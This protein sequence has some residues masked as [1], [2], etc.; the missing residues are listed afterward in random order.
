MMSTKSEWLTRRQCLG[1]MTAS[2]AAA[3]LPRAW[4]APGTSKAQIAITFDLEMSRHY[5]QRGMME[6]D[7]QKG[8]LDDATKQY[9]V[10]AAR[11]V[12]ERGGVIHFFCVG[13]VLEQPDVEWL[14]GLST[15]GHP[16]GNHTYDHVYVLAQTAVETQFRFQRSPWLVEG[17]TAEEVIRENIRITTAALEQRC[18]IK[19]NGFRTPGGF[20]TG[21][22][23]R[24]DI[25]QLLLD[26]GF[27]WVSSK[28]PAHQ[29]GEPMQRPGDEVFADIQRAQAEAQPFVYPSGLIEVPMSPISDVGAFR[30]NYWQRGEF[31]RAVREGVEWA[32]ENAA[33]YDFLC[34][35]S[36]M[37]VED[38][39]F[40]TVEL[41]ADLV[42]QAGGRAEIVGLDAVAER[43][44]QQ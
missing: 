5:P 2:A 18:G 41:M 32:I 21:L 19:A 31:L 27:Q 8:N 42:E 6:W 44:V 15:D 35:P 25:Q 10:E 26:L 36:C 22:E 23:G 37:L 9:A 17:L 3:I 20:S 12:K 14:K 38:P 11:R 39:E 4:A 34:H 33:V 29:A 40:E 30:T 1:V 13:R 24:E 7:Y 16:V 43:V 28:Y